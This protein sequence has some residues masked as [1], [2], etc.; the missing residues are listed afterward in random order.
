MHGGS[1][2]MRAKLSKSKTVQGYVMQCRYVSMLPTCSTTK[3]RCQSFEINLT[4]IQSIVLR[5]VCRIFL[6]KNSTYLKYPTVLQ[7]TVKTDLCSE[8]LRGHLKI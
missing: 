8:K 4:Y 6:G 3:E 7:G 1:F 5:N 2:T